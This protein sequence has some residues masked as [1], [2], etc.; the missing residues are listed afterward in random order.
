MAGTLA[1][2]ADASLAVPVPRPPKGRKFSEISRLKQ[3]SD[4][5]RLPCLPSRMPKW[6]YCPLSRQ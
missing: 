1:C 4:R 2:G 6:A 3:Q 5:R